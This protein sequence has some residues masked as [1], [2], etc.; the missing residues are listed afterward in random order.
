MYDQHLLLLKHRQNNHNLAECSQ[1]NTTSIT[2]NINQLFDYIDSF[3]DFGC[4][5]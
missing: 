2:Y 5:M 1:T 3:T 4:L